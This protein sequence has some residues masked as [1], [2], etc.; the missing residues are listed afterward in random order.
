[1]G[2]R[3]PNYLTF[4]HRAAAAFRAISARRFEVSF[5]AL[6]GPPFFPPG[7]P[8]ATAAGFLAELVS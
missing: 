1:M 5:L 2:Y 8:R 4:F 7:R 3:D 6:A